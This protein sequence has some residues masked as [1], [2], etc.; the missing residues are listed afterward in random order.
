[1]FYK[2]YIKRQTVSKQ[3]P[4]VI[5][6]CE[7]SVVVFIIMDY[8]QYGYES[9]DIGIRQLLHSGTFID[10]Y[11]LHD[12]PWEWPT[13]PKEPINDRQV[14]QTWFIHFIPFKK[15]TLLNIY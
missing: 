6:F 1:M 13:D 8:I 4:T 14:F 5:T 2:I 10:A 9:Y 3:K 11:P 7:R 12:G 15:K